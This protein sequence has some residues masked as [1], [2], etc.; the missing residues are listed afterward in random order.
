LI[1]KCRT[2]PARHE[3]AQVNLAPVLKVMND[4][5]DDTA[6]AVCGHG[7]IEV[8]RAVG[9]VGACKRAGDG[10]FERFGAFLA[11]RCSDADGLRFAL[12][13]QILASLNLSPADYAYWRVEKRC[14][15]FQ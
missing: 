9:T 15:R 6:A 5:A 2:E 3:M 13:A 4:L 14:G 8:N 12:I 7:C 11:K 1:I 10:T